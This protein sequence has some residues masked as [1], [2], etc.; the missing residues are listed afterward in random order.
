M[1]T[2]KIAGRDLRQLGYPEGKVIGIAIKI[3]EKH[4]RGKS[5]HQKLQLMETVIK[6]PAFYMKHET[7][8]PVAK[9]LIIKTEHNEIIP[10][11]GKRKD[12]VVYGEE[13]IEPGAIH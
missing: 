12:Y 3:L 1:A 10:L 13:G 5:R 7:L 2:T 4:Y 9:A 11:E 8:A 6:T